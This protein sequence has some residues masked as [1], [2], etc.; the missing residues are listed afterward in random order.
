MRLFWWERHGQS[1]VPE[2]KL[3][4]EKKSQKQLEQLRQYAKL[5]WTEIKNTIHNAMRKLWHAIFLFCLLLRPV[6]MSPAI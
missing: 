5:K 4:D 2:A 1:K 6:E 3:E